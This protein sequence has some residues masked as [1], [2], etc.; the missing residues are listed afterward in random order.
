MKTCRFCSN[1]ELKHKRDLPVVF[2]YLHYCTKYSVEIGICNDIDDPRVPTWC[3]NKHKVPGRPL[4]YTAGIFN[5]HGSKDWRTYLSNEYPNIDWSHPA[6]V[7]NRLIELKKECE[8]GDRKGNDLFMERLISTD[9]HNIEKSDALL[10]RYF[11]NDNRTVG[12]ICESFYAWRR[13]IPIYM[14]TDLRPINMSNWELAM[15]KIYDED[16]ELLIKRI[17]EDFQIDML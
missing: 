10:I 3:E 13:N 11:S 7:E 6:K 4:V 9:L 8:L 1:Y 2:E 17:I 16:V 5:N 14:W 15:V 12:T